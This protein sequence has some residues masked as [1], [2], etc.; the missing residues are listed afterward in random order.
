M[1]QRS[2]EQTSRPNVIWIQSDQHTPAVTGCYGDPVVET[3]YLDRLAA[4]GTLINGA[5]C[6]SPICVPSRMSV[7][8]GRYPF[9]NEVWTND[10]ILSSAIPTWHSPIAVYDPLTGLGEGASWS[11]RG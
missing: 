10:Q 9:E 7:V 8:T 1:T 5:Y 6:A 3:P 4:R 11:V 2:Q